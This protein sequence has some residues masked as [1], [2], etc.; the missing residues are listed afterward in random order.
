MGPE[1]SIPRI[2]DSYSSD[3]RGSTLGIEML[4]RHTSWLQRTEIQEPLSD[5]HLG[6]ESRA[7]HS[8]REGSAQKP[9]SQKPTDKAIQTEVTKNKMTLSPNS[10]HTIKG[11][12]RSHSMNLGSKGRWQSRSH[13]HCRRTI[14][15]FNI[16]RVPTMDQNQARH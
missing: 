12:P 15:L 2:L 3:S 4:V 7:L 1:N 11:N 5:S 10:E 16:H 6:Q 13:L 8:P 14:Y 9:K